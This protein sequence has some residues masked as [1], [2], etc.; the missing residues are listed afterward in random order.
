MKMKLNS[1]LMAALLFG[2]AGL[3]ANAASATQ[4]GCETVDAKTCVGFA[5]EAMGGRQK[6]A[7]ISNEQLDIMVHTLLT[8]QSYRQ[9]PFI[10][11]YDRVLRTVDFVKQREV[12]ELHSLW[13]ESD[14][15]TA[16]AESSVTVVASPQGAVVRTSGADAPASQSSIDSARAVLALGPERLLLTADA[17]PDLHFESAEMLRSTPHTV[18]AF[19]WNGIP[20]RILINAFNHLP[21][22]MESTRPFNDFWFVWGD[23]SQRVY[24]DNWK[25]IQGVV[26]PTN[27]IEER[28]GILW[29]SSQ[30]LGA[31]FNVAPDDKLF[32]MDPAAATKS[33]QSKGWNRTFDDQNHVALAPGVDLYQGAWNV[34]LIKQDDGVLVLETPISPSF[35]EGVLAKAHA[36]YPTLPIKAVLSTSD[37]WPHI[38]GIREAVA[39]KLPV[40]V[41]DLN[42]P[43]L[44]RI[45]N[46]PHTMIPDHLQTN[47]QPAHW[48]PVSGK[49]EIG[50]GANRV[51]LYPLRGAATERQYM[52]YFPEH[53]LL[54][55]SD[56]LALN[57]Q[58]H[59]LY[60][61]ELMREVVQA[62][63]REHLK[64]DTVYAMH[65]GPTPWNDVTRLVTAAMR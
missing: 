14:P 29:S 32:A 45:V 25:V 4:P 65:Q 55:A 64:V 23:V 46:A 47:P 42:Q 51:A 10:T 9:A 15:D 2:L 58:T 6:L 17:A 28:N 40:Y 48:L 8:E 38:A 53:K 24:Y 13:P 20:V 60:D 52:V 5:M 16:S 54:Y 26:Y 59:A 1:C 11:S 50:T 34:T 22:A 36:E 39:E 43:L 62:A 33:T 7:A 21:D 63:T 19:L 44:D 56:T 41:L 37:S 49:V 30:V 61:P 35:T 57:S 27:R 31:K 12:S 18:V 3:P